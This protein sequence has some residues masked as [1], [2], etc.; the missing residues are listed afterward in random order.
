MRASRQLNTGDF[1]IRYN[2]DDDAWECWLV[3]AGEPYANIVGKGKFPVRAVAAWNVH[4]QE[5]KR[6]YEQSPPA[7][8]VEKTKRK[9]WWSL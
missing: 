5:A 6:K 9:P 3:G 4:A 2:S 1:V 8:K 7:P